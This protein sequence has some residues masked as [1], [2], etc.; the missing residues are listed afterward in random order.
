MMN[1][2]LTGVSW[3]ASGAVTYD[4]SQYQGD[5]NGASWVMPDGTIVAQA[6]QLYP[7]QELFDI[8]GQPGDQLL[9]FIEIEKYTRGLYIDAYIEY[10]DWN[11]WGSN[12]FDAYFAHDYIPNSWEYDDIREDNYDYMWMDYSWPEEGILWMVI[13][14]KTEIDAMT[15]YTGVD[16]AD[17]PPSLDEMTE[18]VNEIPVTGQ[19][20][21]AG[22]GAPDEDR[23]LY[24]YVTENLSSPYFTYGGT[25]NIN[26]AIQSNTVPDPFNSF[27]G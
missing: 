16:I 18:L 22:R 9:F 26:L 3:R 6:V 17:P 5:I 20:I 2:H 7:D 10:Y 13:V 4:T 23:V 25:G 14:P 27:W 15:I 12:N 21:D 1:I 19:K 11:D 8:T 24:Y